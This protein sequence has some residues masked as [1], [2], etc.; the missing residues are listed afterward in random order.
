MANSIPKVN[1]YREKFDSLYGEP[2]ATVLSVRQT[3]REPNRVINQKTMKGPPDRVPMP[4]R[5][6]ERRMLRDLERRISISKSPHQPN[7]PSSEPSTPGTPVAQSVAGMVAGVRRSSTPDPSPA[8]PAR[9]GTSVAQSIAE[10]GGR[11]SADA[12]SVAFPPSA[13]PPP[14]NSPHRE[15]VTASTPSAPHTSSAGSA[16]SSTPPAR[17]LGRPSKGQKP[18]PAHP[19]APLPETSHRGSITASNPSANPRS[20]SGSARPSTPTAGFLGRLSKVQR[21]LGRELLPALPSAPLPE[22]SHRGSIAVSSPSAKPTSSSGSVLAGSLLRHLKVQRPLGRPSVKFPPSAPPPPDN[23]SHRGSVSASNTSENSTPS[24][25]STRAGS[26]KLHLAVRPKA[27]KPINRT[28]IPVSPP[29]DP[30]P[31]EIIYV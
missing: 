2:S 18:L 19:S 25:E 8:E 13:L 5:Q 30:Q 10:M 28:S 17:F 14:E 22:T 26:F 24:S 31:S 21:P 29:A 20:S 3:I 7:S 1:Q 15:S 16:R 9:S 27:Q 12:T 4:S 6:E 11:K 23:S